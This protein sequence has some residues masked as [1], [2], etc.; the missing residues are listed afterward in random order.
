[1]LLKVKYWYE[2]LGT[3]NVLN[4]AFKAKVDRVV[5]TSS[6][7]AIYT[8]GLTNKTFSENDWPGIY[9]NNFFHHIF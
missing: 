4:A 2:Y 9:K 6:S 1:M 8:F 3:L 7:A 5:L